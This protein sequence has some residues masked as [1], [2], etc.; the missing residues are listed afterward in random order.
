MSRLALTMI[1]RNEAVRL[2]DFLAHHRGL[3]D[4]LVVVDTGSS[5]ETVPILA[6]AGAKVIHH[7][8]QD[9]F[10]A[11]RNT[12][13]PAVTAEWVLFADA[14]ERISRAD[15]AAVR[16]A[17]EGDRR[18]AFLQE[19]WNYCREAGHLEWVPVRGRYP[20][21]ESGQTGMFVARRVGLFPRLPDLKFSG[22][23]HESVL[24]AVQGAGL[25]VVPLDVPVHHYG[26]SGSADRNEERRDRYRRL[27]ELKYADDPSDP[28]AQLE[29]ATVRLEDGDIPAAL[30]Q[31]AV[32]VGGPPGL[33]PVVRGLFL[34]GR[35]RREM[36]EL[37]AARDLLNRAVAQDPDFVFGWL[38]RIRVEAA[39]EDWAGADELLAQAE[40]RFGPR[41]PHLLRETLRVQVKRGRLVA[42]LATCEELV[43]LYPQWQEI[44]D[45]CVR[46]EHL[47]NK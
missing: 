9:D 40:A 8:W 1:V 41:H 25:R 5:D 33:R 15:F 35:L 37:T 19:T 26:Y 14:D 21:E 39:A 45:L 3:Y 4:E 6:T 22:R 30:K 34:S 38:E 31:L 17:M 24:P 23:V 27:V 13:L 16:A 20:V 46:L 36:G 11:A 10:A 32:L 42:A 18:Q 29:L 44:R 7:T 28:A 43:R 2:P 47:V 12:A